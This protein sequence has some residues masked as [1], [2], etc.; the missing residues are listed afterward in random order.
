[1]QSVPE[2]SSEQ[3]QRA[4][5][6]EVGNCPRLRKHTVFINGEEKVVFL[7]RVAETKLAQVK[8]PQLI[9]PVRKNPEIDDWSE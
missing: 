2:E 5:L 3:T 8:E 4:A 1:M 6:S 7:E 9:F